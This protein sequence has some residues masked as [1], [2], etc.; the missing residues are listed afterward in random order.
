MKYLIPVV[1]LMA[2]VNVNG[3]DSTQAGVYLSFSLQGTA[4]TLDD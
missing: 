4:W 2:T 3:Q 1:L